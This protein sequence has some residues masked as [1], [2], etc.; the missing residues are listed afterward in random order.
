M[1]KTSQHFFELPIDTKKNYA[2]DRERFHGF[3]QSG[4]EKLENEKNK[5]VHEAFNVVSLDS[6]NLPNDKIVPSFGRNVTW[7]SRALDKLAKRLLKALA[8]ALNLDSDHFTA[9]YKRPF[10]AHNFTTL[11]TL[12]Y[13]TQE[14]INSGKMRLA[15]HT[16]T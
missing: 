12:Y 1:F 3:I 4:Q 14:T 6:K 11:R 2:L 7:L 10:S 16:G 8:L 5:A 9:M 15:E 13:P